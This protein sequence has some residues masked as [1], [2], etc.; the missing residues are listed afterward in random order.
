VLKDIYFF[1]AKALARKLARNEVSETLALWH[2]MI[3]AIILGATLTLN[4]KAECSEQ[5]EYSI[6]VELTGFAISGLITYW[7]I[8]SLFKVNLRI[9]SESFFLR[10]A[11]LSLPSGMQVFATML[12]LFSIYGLTAGSINSFWGNEIP[13]VAWQVTG[14]LIN[15]LMVFL[16]FKIML[17]SYNEIYIQKQNDAS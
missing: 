11:A 14:E 1:K 8:S 16:F 9:D 12:I 17:S 13:L 4:F 7:G 15:C 10:Y 5:E 3:Q 2:F 6:L